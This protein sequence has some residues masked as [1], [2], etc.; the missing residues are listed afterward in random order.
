[1]KFWAACQ[2]GKGDYLQLKENLFAHENVES[3]YKKIK[4]YQDRE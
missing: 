3:L 4:A 1:M 2:L